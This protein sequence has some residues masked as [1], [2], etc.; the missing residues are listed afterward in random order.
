[1]TLT[2]GQLAQYRGCE[3]WN[4]CYSECCDAAAE[5]L[6]RAGEPNDESELAA[7]TAWAATQTWN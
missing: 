1:M 5:V 7:A 4:D 2:P 3:P 6:D